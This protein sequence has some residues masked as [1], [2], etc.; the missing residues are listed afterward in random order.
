MVFKLKN[1]IDDDILN[2]IN[3]INIFHI[4]F[5][6]FINCETSYFNKKQLVE[7]EQFIKTNKHIIKPYLSDDISTNVC[8]DIP[9]DKYP[10]IKKPSHS[11]DNWVLQKQFDNLPNNRTYG[12]LY[13]PELDN[14]L[15]LEYLF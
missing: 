15:Y 14:K 8:I 3:Y 2:N 13:L 10:F 11:G 9:T 1:A 7:L 4:A 12:I 6:K 5:S